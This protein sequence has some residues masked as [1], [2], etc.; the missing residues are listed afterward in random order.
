MKVRTFNHASRLFANRCSLT[1]NL[2]NVL[3]KIS[4]FH[5]QRTPKELI[6]H[7]FD[8]FFCQLARIQPIF[9][10]K[11]HSLSVTIELLSPV[12]IFWDFK[13]SRE[14]NRCY[15]LASISTPPQSIH[16]YIRFC[17]RMMWNP[18]VLY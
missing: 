11:K 18:I 15:L 6:F 17:N 9:F 1:Q 4:N 10:T 5:N 7:V 3:I 14:S 8:F 13:I 12:G 2:T 16:L